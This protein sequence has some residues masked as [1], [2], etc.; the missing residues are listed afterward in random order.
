MGSVRYVIHRR[1]DVPEN[2]APSLL[3]QERVCFLNAELGQKSEEFG[4]RVPVATYV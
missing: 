4:F 3:P 1:S 2:K